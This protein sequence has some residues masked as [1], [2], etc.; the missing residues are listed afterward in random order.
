MY[1]WP[2]SSFQTGKALKCL[3]QSRKETT[4]PYFFHQNYKQR[5]QILLRKGKQD[6]YV[7][8]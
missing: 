7:G 1:R 2:H 5:Y 3:A 6:T 4:L 8:A